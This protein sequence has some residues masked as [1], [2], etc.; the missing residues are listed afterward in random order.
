MNKIELVELLAGIAQ[1]DLIAGEDIADHPCSVAIRAIEQSF[2]D[3]KFL[4]KIVKGT[5]NPRSK[6]ATLLLGLSYSPEW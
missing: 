6:R 1:K 4:K 3:V 2:V 5:A